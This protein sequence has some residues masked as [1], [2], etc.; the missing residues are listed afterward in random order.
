M[1]KVLNARSKKCW[2]GYFYIYSK[3]IIG[4]AMFRTQFSNLGLTIST[5]RPVNESLQTEPLFQA[6]PHPDF[7]QH[8]DSGVTVLPV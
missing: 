4:R 8:A 3:W 5:I 2:P 1:I 6:M 7:S